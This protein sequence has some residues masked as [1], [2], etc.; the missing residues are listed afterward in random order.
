MKGTS[1]I[2][3]ELTSFRENELI[4]ASKLYREK[5]SEVVDEAT[6]YK[7]LE[8]MCKSGEL[9]RIARGIYILP[10]KSKYGIVPLSENE[11]ID[12]FTQNGKGTI[13][14]NSLYNKLGLTT[15]IPKTIQV[16]SSALEVF[17][18]TIQNVVVRKSGLKYDKDIENMVH[19]LDVLQNFNTIQDINY[20]AFVNFSRE[21]AHNYSDTVFEQVLSEE[22]FKKSTISF[23]KNVLNYYGVS[24]NLNRYLSSMSKYSHPTME[25][26]YET[27]RIN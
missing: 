25:E 13:V 15:Q 11:I 6:Y 20:K 19:V 21:F 24:N 7:V 8:R 2:K 10:K 5:L 4:F 18:K 23:L 17:S 22:K 14:G 26:I 27:A 3:A 12:A 1:A 16:M 9:V